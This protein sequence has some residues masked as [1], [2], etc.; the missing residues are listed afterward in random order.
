MGFQISSV[1]IFA[2]SGG[3]KSVTISLPSE[4]NIW[5][6]YRKA[7]VPLVSVESSPVAV[8]VKTSVPGAVEFACKSEIGAGGI[9][10]GLV[11]KAFWGQEKMFIHSI[12]CTQRSVSI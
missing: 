1:P 9:K 6:M 12:H 5:K 10:S 2:G 3:I 4:F 7:S 8:K 11:R